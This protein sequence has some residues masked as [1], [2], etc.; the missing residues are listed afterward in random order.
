[1]NILN[2]HKEHDDMKRMKT[3]KLTLIIFLLASLG[4][5]ASFAS[6]G[7]PSAFKS[8]N[9]YFKGFLG[10]GI[11]ATSIVGSVIAAVFTQNPA[12]LAFILGGVV[13][14]S[15][16]TE[17]VLKKLESKD[18]GALGLTENEMTAWNEES[19][20]LSAVM[21]H[22]VNSTERKYDRLDKTSISDQM[23]NSIQ[24][25]FSQDMQSAIFK[26]KVL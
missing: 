21:N 2:P 14:D 8:K 15:D 7:I 4:N 25:H 12:I 3:L 23:N 5:Q 18:A 10:A 6:I 26:M 1:M 11:L 20:S 22:F 24:D 16:S 13:L 9:N 17:I 19:D